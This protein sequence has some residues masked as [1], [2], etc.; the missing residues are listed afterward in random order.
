MSVVTK[1]TRKFKCI[2]R[3][4]KWYFNQNGSRDIFESTVNP[5]VL[6]TLKD[7]SNEVHN[8]VLIGGLALSYW[9]LP[10]YTQ[11]VDMLFLRKEDLPTQVNKLSKIIIS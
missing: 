10:R 6:L 11:D 3:A 4:D 1:I 8:C 5:E 2:K 7:F 9:A